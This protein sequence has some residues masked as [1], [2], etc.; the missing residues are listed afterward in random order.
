MTDHLVPA[1]DL[2]EYLRRYVH[3]M[4]FGDDD[5]G[6]VLDRY[7]TP[8][9]LWIT[10]GRPLDRAALAAHAHPSRRNVTA[11]RVDVHD[12][13]VDG[14]RAA[15]RYTL[16]ATTRTGR[17]IVTDIHLFG[18]LAPDGRMRRVNQLT[19]TPA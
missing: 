4:A 18:V 1:T 5:P 12:A 13:L 15:A 2:A 19:R 10:D 7:H 9:I 8:D 17:E 3:E 14:D 6:D 16:T 11:C